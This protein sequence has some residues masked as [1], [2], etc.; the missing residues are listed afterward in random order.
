MDCGKV[1]KVILAER[2]RAK[3]NCKTF[4]LDTGEPSCFFTTRFLNGLYS[5]V[6]NQ[7]SGK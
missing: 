6:K 3:E 5:A 2:V 1:E 4:G 7:R